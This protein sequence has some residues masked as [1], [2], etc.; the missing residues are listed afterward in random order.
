[1]AIRQ[2]IGDALISRHKIQ[3]MESDLISSESRTYWYHNS[4]GYHFVSYKIY[5]ETMT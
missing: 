1:M 3:S 4:L 2:K 5:L